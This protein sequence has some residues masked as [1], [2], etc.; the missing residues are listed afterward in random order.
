MTGARQIL[1]ILAVVLIGGALSGCS[2]AQSSS[3]GNPP[4]GNPSSGDQTKPFPSG[5]DW[6]IMG[7]P[8]FRT[9]GPLDGTMV[10]NI[11]T[12]VETED[13]MD[14][15]AREIRS[16]F[17]DL[18]GIEISLFYNSG[19]PRMPSVEVGS[20][21]IR[22]HP[23]GNDYYNVEN[24]LPQ[25]VEYCDNAYDSGMDMASTSPEWGCWQWYDY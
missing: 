22:A 19:E 2:E 8:G 17:P 4:S 23:N 9:G 16:E 18:P 10:L 15:I 21:D 20:A 5:E 3:E 12:P 25:Q 6:E 24:Y 13:E 1:V 14:S 7:S 11:E